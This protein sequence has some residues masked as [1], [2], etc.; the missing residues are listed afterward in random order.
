MSKKI[1]GFFKQFMKF[2]GALWLAIAIVFFITSAGITY[3]FEVP[4]I[5]LFGFALAN[6]GLA[7]L[8]I[9]IFDYLFIDNYDITYGGG[10]L[11][12]S[13]IFYVAKAGD[14]GNNGK[15]IERPFLTIG[16]A[17]ESSKTLDEY[18]EKEEDDDAV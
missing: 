4:F 10:I 14:D 15:S 7:Y 5:L 6:F 17:I 9:F 1:W 16:A 12:Q 18:E 13:Q 8:V 3:L 2:Y 11:D